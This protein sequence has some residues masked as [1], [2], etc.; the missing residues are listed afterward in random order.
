ML[1]EGG[2]VRVRF[3]ERFRR[4]VPLTAREALALLVALPDPG[5]PGAEALRARLRRL[6]GAA[7]DLPAR[8]RRGSPPASVRARVAALDA[9]AEARRRVRLDYFSTSRDAAVVAT[10][11]P[12]GVAERR[13]DLYLVARPV[14]GRGLRTFRVDRIRS[15][16]DAGPATASRPFHWAT[17]L[18]PRGR[19]RRPGGEEVE[20]RVAP[21]ASSWVDPRDVGGRCREDPDGSLRLLFRAASLESV[22]RWLLPLGARAEALR[23][24]AL[25]ARL[26]RAAADVLSAHG[27]ESASP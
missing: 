14:G 18:G 4:P 10:V 25:R 7:A 3:A 1:V 15:L 26:A 9:A 8:I 5:P 22:A 27:V 24:P 13:G 23:P 2:T 21:E 20:V 19:P 17:A 6:L 12:C 11:E 16:A